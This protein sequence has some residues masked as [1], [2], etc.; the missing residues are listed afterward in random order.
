MADSL[1]ALEREIAACRRCP[2]L[3]AWLIEVREHPR[4]AFR[5]ERYWCRPVPAFGPASAR[6][7]IVGLAPGAHGANR[8]GRPF[9]GD[10]AGPFLYSALARAGFANRGES[11]ARDDGLALTDA[12]ITNAARCAPPG[13]RPTPQELER[14]GEFLA[15][16]LA[17]CRSLRAVLCLG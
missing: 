17:L 8:T 16:E 15:R 9:T 3:T 7:L 2:R 14:C 10:G 11:I 12:R 13:N 5:G 6:L 1:G 4:A